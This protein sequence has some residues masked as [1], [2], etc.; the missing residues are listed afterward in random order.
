MS[1]VDR[2]PGLSAALDELVPVVDGSRADWN[3][4]VAR[5]DTR[6]K[7]W[8]GRGRSRSRRL[9][10]AIV[11]ALLFLLLAGAATATYL[12]LRGNGKIVFQGSF[13]TL[14][15]AN[16]NGPGL[17]AIA[18]C[19]AGRPSCAIFEPAWS[20]DGGRLAFVRGRCCD[21]PLGRR[22]DSDMSLYVAAADGRAAR[23]LASCGNC[24]VQYQGQHLGWL[25]NG[26]WIAFTRRGPT[27]QESLWVVAAA[28]GRLHRLTDCRALCADVQPTWSPN[29]RLLAFQR[30]T[31]AGSTIYIVRPDGSGLTRIAS[32]ADPE[33]SPDGSR[34]AFDDKGRIEIAKADGSPVRLVFA[35]TPATGPGAPSWSPDGRKLVFFTT[36][37]RPGH[38]RLEVWTMNA[39]GSGKERLYRSGC[40][41]GYGAPP[42]WSPDGRLIAFSDSAAGGTFV[43]NADGSG[44]R[45]LSPITSSDL[46]WQQRPSR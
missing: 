8:F 7:L 43:I 42:I 2:V 25:P 28:G 44:L 10:L 31:P 20:R 45:R 40:C 21:F 3:D 12:L 23:R 1:R 41:T 33:W 46:S 34:I 39:D 14:L 38:F 27:W 6:R 32:G 16:P 29:G 36:P 9:R 24:G 18:R 5:A 19:A 4:V 35:G 37:G 15:V 17:R 13:G 30:E 22:R 26:R 11:V